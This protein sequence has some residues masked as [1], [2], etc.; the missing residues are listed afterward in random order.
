MKFFKIIV[1]L[2][3][4]V[5][6]SHSAFALTLEECKRASLDNSNLLQAYENLIKSSIYSN[7]KDKASLFPQLTAFYQPDYVQFS[8]RSDFSYGYETKVGLTLSLDLNKLLVDYPQ[9]SRL[10]IEKNKLLK[11]VAENEIQKDVTQNYY[12]IYVFLKKK[13]D[14]QDADS[15]FKEHIKDI[16]NLQAKG[17]DVKLDLIRADVQMKSLNIALGN[18]NSEISNALISLNSLMRTSYKEEDFAVM[19]VPDL[20]AIQTDQN[21]FDENIPEEPIEDSPI[22]NIEKI[23]PNKIFKLEQSKLDEFDLKIAKETYEQSKFY[24]MPSLQLGVDHNIRTVDP[25]VEEYKSYLVLNFNLFDF[26]QK[27]NES[28]KLKYNY[29]YQKNFFEENQ[30]KLKVR[31]DQLIIEIENLQTT[32]KN[33]LDNLKSAQKSIDTAKIYYQQGKIKETDLLSVFSESMSV[34]DQVYE[35]LYNF[36]S[37]K[38]ELDSMV[39]GME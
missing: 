5:F 27:A 10:E 1:F 34:K 33:A 39:R 16:E 11:S 13:K 35:T 31:I 19:D 12:K 2:F 7:K 26:G 21:V 23:V 17:V 36:F 4:S 30:R 29:E 37:K 9:L 14:Y 15:Y 18:A 20:E 25:N 24:Y 28:K 22:E 32:Y 8:D 6:V 3:L 38:A